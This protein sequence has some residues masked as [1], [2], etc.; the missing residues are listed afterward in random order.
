MPT[1]TRDGQ[2]LFY[3]DAGQG[4]RTLVLAHN[5]LTDHHIFDQVVPKLSARYRMIRV[6]LRGHGESRGVSG[7]F[8]TLELA[9]DLAAVLDHAGV[10]RAV[11]GG[12]SLG[13]ATAMAFA[14]KWPRRVDGLALMAATAR[15]STAYDSTQ[16]NTLALAARTV[17]MRSFLVRKSVASLLGKTTLG[18]SPKLVESL[19]GRIAMLAPSDA[20]HAIRCWLSRP[21]AAPLLSRVRG[22]PALIVIGD[23]DAAIPDAHTRELADSFTSPKVVNVARAGHTLPFEQPDEVARILAG[24]LG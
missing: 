7:A 11:I 20:Y 2:K 1:L 23:E 9:E 21:A 13:A 17:G 8:T 3:D 14:S 6:D 24:F 22:V 19:A 18:A 16:L 10:T 5:L 12:V 4:D 15:V